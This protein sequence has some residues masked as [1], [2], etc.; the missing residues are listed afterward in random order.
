MDGHLLA[1]RFGAVVPDMAIYGN[2]VEY[3][4]NT[5]DN[6][7]YIFIGDYIQARATWGVTTI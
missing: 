6:H 3:T 7:S 2:I 4:S 5:S 1:M